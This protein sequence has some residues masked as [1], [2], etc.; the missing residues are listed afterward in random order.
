MPRAA[1]TARINGDSGSQHGSTLTQPRGDY[2]EDRI[3]DPGLRVGCTGEFI[4]PTVWKGRVQSR[5]PQ[6]PDEF[7]GGEQPMPTCGAA[8]IYVSGDQFAAPVDDFPPQQSR[9]H[10]R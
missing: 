2:S 8:V 3:L 9:A 7:H 10:H 1:D 5:R 6:P 4:S